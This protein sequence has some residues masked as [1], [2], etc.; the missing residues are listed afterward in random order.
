MNKLNPTSNRF[1]SQRIN[2]HYL[3][4]GNPDAPLL[5]LV[6][7]ARDHARSWDWVAEELRDDWHIVCP[8]LRGHGDSAWSPDGSYTILSYVADLAQLLHQIGDDPV[9]IAAHSLGG[10]IAL[11][12]AGLFPQKVRRLA[13]IEGL[14]IASS[15][16]GDLFDQWRDWMTERRALSGRSPR[17]YATLEEA[18]SRMRAANTYL[19]VEQALH[20]TVHGSTRNEDGTFSWKFD[21]YTRSN[22]PLGVSD[23]DVHR[24]W[25]CINCPVWLVHGADSWA[26]HPG[27]DGRHTFFKQ[28]TVTSYEE[29]GHWV[30]HDRLNS[31][32]S[33]LRQFLE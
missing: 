16:N 3:D 33:D 20:L 7:G 18:F 2:L 15:S 14:G 9:S 11:R 27:T 23:A 5:V 30:H 21:N 10:A 13:A 8:D 32:T 31:F 6:H 17:R 25:G 24:L 28:A 26:S 4:W 29:A 19:S 1:T 12:Y 22:F